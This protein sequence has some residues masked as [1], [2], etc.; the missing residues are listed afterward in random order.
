MKG[1]DACQEIRIRQAT[2]YFD[3]NRTLCHQTKK[4]K[5]KRKIKPGIPK[6]Y[7]RVGEMIDNEE[8]TISNLRF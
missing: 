8:F 7:E 6:R 2:H 3:L 4:K 5:E 1:C